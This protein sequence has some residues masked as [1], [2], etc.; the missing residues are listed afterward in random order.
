[1]YRLS[2][3]WFYR[4]QQYSELLLIPSCREVA[5]SYVSFLYSCYCLLRVVCS[6]MSL[7]SHVSHSIILGSWDNM[8]VMRQTLD[9]KVVSLNPGRSSRRIFF[10][11]VNFVCLLLFTVHYTPLLPQWLK[12]P[13][14]SAKS[15]GGR[16]NLNMQTSVTQRS[17]SG[18]TMPLSTKRAHTQLVREHSVTVISAR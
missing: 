17:R 1:M 11:R 10:S 9:Q 13:G 14:H 18:L 16:L 4:S 12:N 8:L 3:S 5:F 7:H 6:Y 15:A 2:E